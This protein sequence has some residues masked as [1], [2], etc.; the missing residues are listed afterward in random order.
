[1]KGSFLNR[2]HTSSRKRQIRAVIVAKRNIP[3]YMSHRDSIV[4][5][6]MHRV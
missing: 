4:I 2:H 6:F 3:L 1:M 5:S